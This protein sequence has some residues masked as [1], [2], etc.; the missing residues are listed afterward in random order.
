[1]LGYRWPRQTGSSFSDCPA[2]YPDG[3]ESFVDNYGIVCLHATKNEASAT[4]RLRTLLAAAYGEQW[5]NNKQTELLEQVAHSGK[6]LE[7]WLRNS[8][9]EQHCQLFQHRPF[10]WQIWDGQKNGFSILVNYH[11]LSRANLEKITF[12][13]LGDWITKQKAA[14]ESGEEGSDARLAAAHDLQHKLQLILEGEQPYDIFIRWKPLDKQP[15]GW[16]PDLNDGVRLNIRPF[17]TAG[18]LRRNPKINWNKDRGTDVASAPWYSKFKGERIN[19]F[20]LTLEEKRKSRN[21]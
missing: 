1:L 16:E 11:K 7:D 21:K 20:H 12:S 10:I 4:E 14:V 8:F 19:D 5:S 13:Y 9:F 2:L 15:N 6:P 18:V 17:I 3:L